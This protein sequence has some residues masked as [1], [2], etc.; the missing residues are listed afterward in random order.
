MSEGLVD[1]LESAFGLELFLARILLHV[2]QNSEH[3]RKP[4]S[5]D[6][7][8]QHL[9]KSCIFEKNFKLLLILK[10]KFTAGMV[11]SNG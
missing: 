1:L 3:V 9:K 10:N 4:Q 6:L 8:R 11:N 2:V 5:F 7:K